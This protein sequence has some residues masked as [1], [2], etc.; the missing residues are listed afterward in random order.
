MPLA[1]GWR[2]HPPGQ[3]FSGGGWIELELAAKFQIAE[4]SPMR[5][6]RILAVDCGA[7]HVA[8]GLFA[9]ESDGPL[10]LARFSTEFLPPSE[11][12][13][14]E[15]AAGVGA[16]LAALGRRE[17]LHGACILGVPGHLTFTKLI[18]VPRLPA[19]QRRK[20]IRFEA[21]Q[22]VPYTLEEVVWCHAPVAES[23]IGWEVALTAARRSLMETLCA[24]IREAGFYPVAIVPPWFV[25]QH[26]A[27]HH[28]PES[29]ATHLLS[30]GARSTHLVCG[31]TFRFFMRTFAWGGNAVTQRVADELG[32]EFARAESLKRQVLDGRAEFPADAPESMAVQIAAD[33]FVRQVCGEISRSLAGFYPEG[34]ASRPAFLYLTGG[35]SLI[36]NL[37]AALADKLQMCIERWEPW[38]Q[39]KLGPD[40]TNWS[41]RTDP[42]ALADLIGLAEGAASREQAGVSLLP[43]AWRWELRFLRWWPWM[44][45]AALLVVVGLLVP[46][47]RYRA[48]ASETQR[49]TSA[50]EVKIDALHR[51]DGRNRGNLAHLA[52]TN[53]R[54]AA[55]Q[56][57]AE[58]RSSWVAFLADLQERLVKTE[59]VWLESLQFPPP[60]KSAAQGSKTGETG[61]GSIAESENTGRPEPDSLV[62]ISLTGCLFDSDNPVT[63]AGPG[64]YQRAKSLLEGL[65][66]S[67]FVE[68]VENERFDSSQPGTL[69]FQITLVVASRKLF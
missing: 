68:A 55:L 42:N 35:G 67:P 32:M 54:I 29:G 62:R 13:D 18:K 8:I 36:R 66:A 17:R 21:Q 39:I 27:C 34:G 56:R 63:K 14:E 50:M 65:R 31:E 24:K 69:R 12:G 30:I 47:L 53:R 43:R 25:L 6:S 40:G 7:S 58:A 20:I 16:L 49:R 4:L 37:P 61:L 15:W 26:G 48:K 9:R 57:L 59:D 64:A 1:A 45:A 60:V 41:N 3:C 52:E 44:A 10:R 2:A 46:V 22:G 19:R 51:L 23:E 33:Q 28:H 38:R 11:S 5:S